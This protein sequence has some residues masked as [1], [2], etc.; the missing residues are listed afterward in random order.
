LKLTDL[1]PRFLRYEKR[2]DGREYFVPVETITEAQGIKF[3]CPICFQKNNGP[4]GT[5]GVICWSRSRGI[6]DSVQPGP[7]RWRLDGVGLADLSLNEDPGSRSIAL[8]GG[9]DAHF[10]VTNGEIQIA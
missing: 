9:C 6:A 5:H 2:D 1:E 10:Y 7:G 4:V 8:K 3:L